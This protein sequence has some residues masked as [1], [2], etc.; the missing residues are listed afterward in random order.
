M[1][2]QLLESH[3]RALRASF[4]TIKMP[5]D[6]ELLESLYRAKNYTGMVGFVRTALNLDLRVRVGLWNGNVPQQVKD[7]PAWVEHPKPLPLF[8]TREFRAMLITVN[9]R[10][11]FLNEASF[12]QVVSAIAHELS[13]IMLDAL[14][15]TLRNEEEAVDL[16]AM[17][18]GF[19]DF[20]VTGNDASGTIQYG[21]L[22]REEVRYA[23]HYMTFNAPPPDTL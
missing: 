7:A 5:V 19:R 14:S 9:L 10:K 8:G 23:A 2:T 20:Y 18:L 1:R 4:G 12:E 17:F 16:A 13:H 3:I 6:D 11:S 15:H 21:Y 22:S